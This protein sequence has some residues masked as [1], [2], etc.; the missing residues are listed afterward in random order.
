MIKSMT[1]FGRCEV[2]DNNKKYIVEVKAVNH[3][4][5]ELN[6]KLQKGLACFDVAVRNT[7]KEYMERGKVDIFVSVEDDGKLSERVRY[8]SDIAA[9][10][11]GYLEEMASQFNLENDV[12]LSNLSRYPDVFTME[13]EVPDEDEQWKA[14]EK[15]VRGAC[16]NF[17][18]ARTEEGTNLKNNLISKLDSMKEYVETI[19]KRSPQIVEEY[20][21]KLTERIEEFLSSTTAAV[22]ESRI[23]T[24]VTIYADKVCVDEEIVRL[25]SHIESMRQCLMKGGSCGR[26]LDFI[27]QEMNREANTT[28][29]KANDLLLSDTAIELKTIIEKI[30]EQVQNI[31]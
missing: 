3:R 27:A 21:K 28:L 8:N 10:Y 6:T 24:E 1:G 25:K 17:V 4:Y 9:Q 19:E 29:S 5:L 7:A 18:A 13:D 30:R 20:R 26:K 16:E 31:E 2:S 14:I 15:C 11:M 23:V 22:D 12:R